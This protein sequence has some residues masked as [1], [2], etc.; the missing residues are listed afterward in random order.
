MHD[1]SF[2]MLIGF[3]RRRVI[4]CYL[5][6]LGSIYLQYIIIKFRMYGTGYGRPDGE[7]VAPSVSIKVHS[8]VG[9]ADQRL[10]CTN[11]MPRV[12]GSRNR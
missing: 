1:D 9:C 10:N 8:V 7:C 5:R 4:S 12:A 11:R 3:G 6:D 2:V